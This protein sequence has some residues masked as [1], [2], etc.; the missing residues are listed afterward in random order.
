MGLIDH[1]NWRYATKRFD[2]TKKVSEADLATMQEAIRLSAS[3]FGLQPYKVIV[4]EDADLKAKLLPASWNQPQIV[5][6][7]HLF[8]F[9]AQTH[10]TP[11]DIDAYLTLKANSMGISVE[12]LKG[13]GDFMKDKI[14]QREQADIQDWNSRQAYIALGNLLAAA[15]ELKVDACPMEGFEV[16]QYNEI[17]GLNEQGLSAVSVVPVGYRSEE[18]ATQNAPKVRKPAEELFVVR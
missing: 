8:V 5:E 2:N 16:D 15:G 17:L 12:D 14:G 9:A 11:A 7:S 1:L 18:D 3:S 13:Y 4:V 10:V 6:A